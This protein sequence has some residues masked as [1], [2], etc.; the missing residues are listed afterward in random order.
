MFLVESSSS[1]FAG[2]A[3]LQADA[4]DFLADTLTYSLTLSVLH[5]PLSVRSRAALLKG[6]SLGLM[7]ILVLGAA[8]WRFLTG[9]APEYFTMETVAVLALA[10]NLASVLLLYRFRDG[11]ANMTSVWQCSRNDAIGNLAVF[12]AAI[13][14]S[15]SGS[16][17]PDLAVAVS[18][19]GLFLGSCLKITRQ[20]L[21]ELKTERKRPSRFERRHTGGESKMRFLE[22]SPR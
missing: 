11:D 5:R 20:A 7:A 17:W 19:A 1:L 4:L 22:E 18:M 15:I 6:A 8:I 10:A 2:S 13:G 9:T 3:A 12:A 21:E 14:V 16:A